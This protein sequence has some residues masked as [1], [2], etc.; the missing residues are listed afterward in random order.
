ML[1]SGRESLFESEANN[2]LGGGGL[3]SSLKHRFA[4]F[5]WHGRHE[6]APEPLFEGGLLYVLH[7]ER[8][9]TLFR[10]AL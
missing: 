8:S 2:M 4:F 9:R 6:L 3:A 7:R 1:L 10:V 5:I